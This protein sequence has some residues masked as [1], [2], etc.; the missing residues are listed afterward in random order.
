M[1]LVDSQVLEE[2]SSNLEKMQQHLRSKDDDDDDDD[3]LGDLDDDDEAGET[4]EE[5][6]KTTE[7][8]KV[9]GQKERAPHCR[10]LHFLVRSHYVHGHSLRNISA[11]EFLVVNTSRVYVSMLREHYPQGATA[12]AQ[13]LADN[14][15][16]KQRK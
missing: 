2:E 5:G 3:D 13:P 15:K 4:E 11:Q 6:G 1:V 8:R 7:G 16:W 9:K 10:S 14:S 12:S